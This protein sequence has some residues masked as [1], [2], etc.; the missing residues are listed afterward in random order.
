MVIRLTLQEIW[1]LQD[2][3]AN[4]RR[5]L[6]NITKKNLRDA[7]LVVILDDYGLL[8]TDLGEEVLRKHLPID[9]REHYYL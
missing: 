5:K 1:V 2:V 7:G 9:F 6:D 4:R 8:L 3:K